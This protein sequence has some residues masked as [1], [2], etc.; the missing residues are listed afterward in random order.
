MDINFVNNEV[1]PTRGITWYNEFSS[2]IGLNKKS[3]NLTKIT[4]D[5]TVYA[6]LNEERKFVGIFKFGGGHIFT[7]NFEYFQ[8]L[9]LGANNYAR[10]FRKERF[11]GSGLAYA[12]AEFRVKLIQSQSY[13]LPGDI[14]VIGFYD[15]GKVW[16]RGQ[17]SRKWHSSVGGGLYYSPFNIVIISATMGVSSEDRLLNFSLGTKFHLTF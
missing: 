7:D 4:T 14:G 3:K 12:S 10:G 13:V 2:V 9:T 11:S 6:S 16:M 5:M 8:A 17:D 15:I 1:L